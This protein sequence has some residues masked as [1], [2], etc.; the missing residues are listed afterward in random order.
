M[1]NEYLIRE[2]YAQSSSYPPDIKYQD[3]F[4]SAQ[5]L[6]REESKGLW[7]S[8]CNNWEGKIP[9]TVLQQTQE[10]SQTSGSYVCNCSKTCEQ[11]SSCAEAQYQLNT[12]GCSARDGDKDGI[13]CDSDCQ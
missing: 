13:A 6:A 4:V 8:Y 7:S 10:P 12:C 9:T 2:G 11:M 1:V 5:K 3:R